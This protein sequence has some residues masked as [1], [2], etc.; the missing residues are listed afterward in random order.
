MFPSSAHRDASLANSSPIFSP[1]RIDELSLRIRLN[2]VSF[3]NER[4][5][6]DF[7]ATLPKTLLEL[8]VSLLK[9]KQDDPSRQRLADLLGA[10][11]RCVSG[12]ADA[13]EKGEHTTKVCAE[14]DTYIVNLESF[15]VEETNKETA[16][17][18]TMWLRNVEEVPGRS[19][20]DLA[21]VVESETKPRWTKAHRFEQA[22]SVR[23]TA[24]LIEC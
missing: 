13:I 21:R 9:L 1:I 15:V 20:I 11:A 4:Q 14:L 17:Q 24:G 19:S 6:V 7:L 8:A 16:E 23:H 5:P 3:Q 22:E 10:V 12:I 18:L 2:P